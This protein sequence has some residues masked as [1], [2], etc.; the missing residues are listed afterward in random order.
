MCFVQLY[1]ILYVIPLRR[2][3]KILQVNQICLEMTF[4]SPRI[5]LFFQFTEVVENGWPISSG[6]PA[7]DSTTPLHTKEQGGLLS[8]GKLDWLR[9]NTAIMDG[10]LPFS[11]SFSSLCV[12]STQS[13]YI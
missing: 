5:T 11:L 4:F 2:F 7:A 13:T 6:W 1:S 9:A 3:H 10:S 8:Y 12:A